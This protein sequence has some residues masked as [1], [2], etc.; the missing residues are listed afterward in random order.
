MMFGNVFRVQGA[1]PNMVIYSKIVRK[2]EKMGD[3][4]IVGD[5]VYQ[6][7]QGPG[8]ITKYGNIPENSQKIRKKS[9]KI[10]G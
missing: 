2:S 8:C 9:D 1:L 4:P 3:D 5:D 10:E 6:C 7:I